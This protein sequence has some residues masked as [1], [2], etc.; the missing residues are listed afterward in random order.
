MEVA[1]IWEAEYFIPPPLL[2]ALLGEKTSLRGALP[3]AATVGASPPPPLRSPWGGFISLDSPISASM[4]GIVLPFSSAAEAD[5]EERVGV[6]SG[7]GWRG[8]ELERERCA[9]SL[10]DR[11]RCASSACCC[12]CCGAS[13]CMLLSSLAPCCSG[14]GCGWG[15]GWGWCDSSPSSMASSSSRFTTAADDNSLF[16]LLIPSLP[17]LLSLSSLVGSSLTTLSDGMEEGEERGLVRMVLLVIILFPWTVYDLF[18]ASLRPLCFRCGGGG[19]IS[20]G[21]YCRYELLKHG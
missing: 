16:K 15:C 7:R 13:S 4:L 21:C 6:T 10:F 2:P 9:V 5:V 1:K 8:W 18:A 20:C 17:S 3:D 11:E 14:C 12:C 19:R